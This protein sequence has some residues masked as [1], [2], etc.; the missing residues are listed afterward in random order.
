MVFDPSVI[1]YGDLL[2]AF[3]E[4]HDPTQGMRQGNDVGTTYRSAIYTLNDD[5]QREADHQRQPDEDHQRQVVRQQGLH[6]KSLHLSPRFNPAPRRRP[7]S[8]QSI[9][10]CFRITQGFAA[11]HNAAV[12]MSLPHMLAP[13][14]KA[15]RFP[16]VSAAIF[17]VARVRRKAVVAV[18]RS[19]ANGD[20]TSVSA[21]ARFV[22][23][24]CRCVRR[25]VAGMP[26]P[27]THRDRAPSAAAPTSAAR[28]A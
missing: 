14:A 28:I 22:S 9:R 13:P 10:P 11:P 17:A 6:R 5:Q 4:N 12:A 27:T 21:P 3:W 25:T 2:K 15:A 16:A 26:G 20:V 1:T 18:R 8:R 7:Q 24:P 19:M 23:G